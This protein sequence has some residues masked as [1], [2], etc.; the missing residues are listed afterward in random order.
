MN[1]I[2]SSAHTIP[3]S[4]SNRFKVEWVKMLCILQQIVEVTHSGICGR[5]FKEVVKDAIESGTDGYDAEIQKAV[6]KAAHG[7]NLTG[8]VSMSFTNKAVAKIFINY[9]KRA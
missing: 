8:E 4:S 1:K 3:V 7:Q 9:I 2:M 6:R 5:L